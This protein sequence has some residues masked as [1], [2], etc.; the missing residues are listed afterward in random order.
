MYWLTVIIKKHGGT[1]IDILLLIYD[2]A[3]NTK[4]KIWGFFNI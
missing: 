4:E 3:L 1:L 2:G